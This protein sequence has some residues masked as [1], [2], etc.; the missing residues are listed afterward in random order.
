VLIAAAICGG[1]L[2]SSPTPAAAG[3]STYS[4]QQLKIR[5][6]TLADS[7]KVQITFNTMPETLYYCPGA[8]REASQ[9]GTLLTFV[10]SFAKAKPKVDYPAKRKGDPAKTSEWSILVDAKDKPIFVKSG[11][12]LVK[13]FPADNSAAVGAI[14]AERI[15]TLEEILKRAQGHHSQGTESPD[16]VRDAMIEL[17]EARVEAAVDQDDRTAALQDLLSVWKQCEDRVE[18]QVQAGIKSR[19]DLLRVRL[20]RLETELRLS[21]PGD[22]AEAA[23]ALVVI[24][25][26]TTATSGDDTDL[27][28]LP[29]VTARSGHKASIKAVT[30]RHCPNDEIVEEGVI[31]NVTPT[32]ENGVV[33]LKG[34]VLIVDD[35]VV[36]E[37]KE[38]EKDVRWIGFRQWKTTFLVVTKD[39]KK[40]Y[41]LGPIQMNGKKYEIWLSAREVAE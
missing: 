40:Q 33:T 15:A 7:G 41:R 25:A 35:G 2:V 14:H 22:A 13:I 12:D 26:L 17:G 32:V 31:L 27:L 8:N 16:V 11:K 20:A 19:E 24:E 5:K 28:S 4:G 39:P 36:P 9:R 1:F 3:D 21:A 23:G 18:Q 30:E 34:S 10:R 38:I 6:V 29:K 37:D